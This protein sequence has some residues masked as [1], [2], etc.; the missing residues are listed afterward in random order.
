VK[1]ENYLQECKLKPL[2]GYANYSGYEGL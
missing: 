1:W 2:A